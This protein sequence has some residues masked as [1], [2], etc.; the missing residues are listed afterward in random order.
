VR[1]DLGDLGSQMRV[2]LLQTR[3][4]AVTQTSHHSHQR[5]KVLQLEEFLKDRVA[6]NKVEEREREELE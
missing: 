1:A 4:G 6:W 2:G 5:I 3:D